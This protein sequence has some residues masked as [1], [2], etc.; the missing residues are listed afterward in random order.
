[1]RRT[2]RRFWT[3][4]LTAA[5]WVGSVAKSLLFRMQGYDATVLAGAVMSLAVVALGAGLIPAHRASQVDP[6]TALRYE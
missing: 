4:G 5:V 6:M 2:Q 3:I 1:M